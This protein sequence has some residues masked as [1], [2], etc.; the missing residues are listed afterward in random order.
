M[1]T[2]RINQVTISAKGGLKSS[3]RRCP[4]LESQ[5]NTRVC[6]SKDLT[7]W[8]YNDRGTSKRKHAP[9]QKLQAP[10]FRSHKSS[11]QSSRPEPGFRA[12]VETGHDV[13]EALAML[14]PQVFKGQV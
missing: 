14:H 1:T 6:Y 12:T 5:S 10:R 7:S 2:G 3:P 11:A 4:K 13:A 8:V 9:N